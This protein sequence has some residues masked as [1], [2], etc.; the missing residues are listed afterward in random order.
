[1]RRLR[2]LVTLSI[3]ACAASAQEPDEGTATPQMREM[4]ATMEHM[5][6]QMA[7]IRAT[8]DSAEREG[9]MREHMESM[10]RG[11]MMMGGMMHGPPAGTADDETTPCSDDDMQCG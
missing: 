1:M 3:I 6:E 2:S 8:D 11:M 9:L 4:R 5:H 7:R 10:H